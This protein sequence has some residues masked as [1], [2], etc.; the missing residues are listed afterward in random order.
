MCLSECI[1]VAL[2][3]FRVVLALC[4]LYVC[5]TVLNVL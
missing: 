4:G 5:C 2:R 3:T 1:C